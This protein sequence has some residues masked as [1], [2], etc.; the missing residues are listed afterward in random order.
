M[1]LL[2]EEEQWESLKAWLRKNGAFYVAVIILTLAGIWGWRWWQQHRGDEAIAAG[3]AYERILVTFDSGKVDEA[4]AQI[5][6]LRGDYPKSAYVW[7]ADLAAARLFVSR[8]ELDK[9]LVR[10][11]RVASTTTDESLK[12]LVTL[13]I[14]RVENALG[15]S[16]AALATLGTGD[17]GAHNAAWSEVRGDILLSKGDKAGALKEYEAARAALPDQGAGNGVGVL[18]DL[19][20]NDLRSEV[21]KP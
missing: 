19:K 10:L 5:E 2:S 18:L 20:I 8:N 11:E 9:A 15:R 13:R 6:A 3:T 14:A 12:P 21:A 16:D 1:E 17:H 7:A 4:L